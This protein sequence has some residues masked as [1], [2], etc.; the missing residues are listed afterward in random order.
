MYCLCRTG[1]W[2]GVGNERHRRVMFQEEEESLCSLQLT[3]SA[4][5]CRGAEQHFTWYMTHLD[6][7]THT[8][9]E[10]DECGVNTYTLFPD[11]RS[12]HGTHKGTQANILGVPSVFNSH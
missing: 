4:D 6:K 8:Y 11:S 9:H 1:T 3:D 10:N 5:L 7:H 12:I 2:A